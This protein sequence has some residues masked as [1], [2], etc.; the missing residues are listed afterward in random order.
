[1]EGVRGVK[2][3]FTNRAGKCLVALAERKGDEV[4]VILLDAPD[5]WWSAAVLVEDAFRAL[6]DARR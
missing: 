4:L 5:R 1:V 6:A 3:G 2:S